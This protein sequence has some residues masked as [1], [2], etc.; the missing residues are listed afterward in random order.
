MKPKQGTKTTS[1]RTDCVPDVRGHAN[2]D[3]SVMQQLEQIRVS[4]HDR[5][6]AREYLRSG[7]RMAELIDRASGNLRSAGAL[8]GKFFARPK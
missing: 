5:Q 1:Q 8:V 4:E 7:E 3:S 2:V 6:L